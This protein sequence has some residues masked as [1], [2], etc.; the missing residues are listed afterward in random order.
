MTDAPLDDDLYALLL[1][2]DQLEALREDL[3]DDDDA[4]RAELEA[5]GLASLAA[6]SARIADLHAR[7]DQEANH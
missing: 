6:L 4:A 3:I 5:L 1:E 7:L 2:L